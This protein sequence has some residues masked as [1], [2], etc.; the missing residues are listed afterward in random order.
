MGLSALVDVQQRNS[1]IV[2]TAVPHRLS[3]RVTLYQSSSAEGDKPG[4][5][6]SS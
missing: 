2:L 3:K 1:P 5:L 4:V 6:Q